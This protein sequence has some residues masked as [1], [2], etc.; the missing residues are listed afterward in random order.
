MHD[1]K[2]GKFHAKTVLTILNGDE[3]CTVCKLGAKIE[4]SATR[5]EYF[6]LLSIDNVIKGHLFF[7]QCCFQWTRDRIEK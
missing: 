7:E 5:G 1:G 6:I 2:W 3:F 4:Q